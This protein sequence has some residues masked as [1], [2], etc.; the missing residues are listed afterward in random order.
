MKKTVTWIV[1][2]DGQHARA[3]KNEGPGRGIMALDDFERYRN[4]LPDRELGSDQ[5]GR[6]SSVYGA[7][8]DSFAPKTSLHEREEE[9]FILAIAHLL[10]Q[11]L[12]AGQFD[13]LIMIAPPKALG[14]LRKTLSQNVQ[15]HMTHALAK[16]LIKASPETLKM[17]LSDIIA[18]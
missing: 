3:Y 4:G 7:G 5:P 12:S 10:D 14:F 8:T 9:R 6:M 11:A 15:K 1:L 13:R 18:L 17:Q 2:V 16:D